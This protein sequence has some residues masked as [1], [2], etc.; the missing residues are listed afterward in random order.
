MFEEMR[1]LV[2]IKSEYQIRQKSKTEYYNRG[3]II[4]R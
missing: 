3:Q 1:E 2:T 4:L